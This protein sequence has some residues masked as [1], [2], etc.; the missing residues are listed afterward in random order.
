MARPL[1]VIVIII[2]E[3]FIGI[4]GIVTGLNLLIDPSGKRMGLDILLDKIPLNDFS[5]LGAWFFFVYGTLPIFLA[6]G[7]WK[8]WSW[9]WMG[10]LILAIIMLIWVLG[11]IYF[12]GAS[13]LQAV[14][15]AIALITIY[16]LYHQTVKMYFTK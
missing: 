2:L 5:L 9:S 11:Q 6:L 4:L 12:V 16:F 10:T 13:I 14:F 3:L 8:K 15:G 7:F 1:G